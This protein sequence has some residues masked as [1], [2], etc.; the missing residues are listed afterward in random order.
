MKYLS[1]IILPDMLWINK[2]STEK[3]FIAFKMLIKILY[4]K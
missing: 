3:F 1:I 4:V 2:T